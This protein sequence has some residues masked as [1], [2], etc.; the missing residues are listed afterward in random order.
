MNVWRT[1]QE[2]LRRR[3]GRGHVGKPHF[4]LLLC[5]Q[6]KSYQA[7]LL[8]LY[9]ELSSGSSPYKGGKFIPTPSLV[10]A[11]S[12]QASRRRGRPLLPPQLVLT[13]LCSYA[14]SIP[15]QT[16]QSREEYYMTEH[17]PVSTD[18]AE[19]PARHFNKIK[20]WKM[21]P[22]LEVAV[23]PLWALEAVGEP[24]WYLVA[25]SVR[26][27]STFTTRKA[28]A[29]VEFVGRFV[30]LTLLCAILNVAQWVRVWKFG[31]WEG[32]LLIAYAA[33]GVVLAVDYSVWWLKKTYS[34]VTVSQLYFARILT[35]A[36]YIPL[37]Y[38]VIYWIS[39]LC[40]GS[41]C[42]CTASRVSPGEFATSF[43]FSLVTWTNL[44]YGD[45]TPPPEI[46]LLVTIE[47]LLGYAFLGILIV[48]LLETFRKRS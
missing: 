46:R 9:R 40:S 15:E 28:P 19:E 16:S 13:R 7:P 47:A 21:R 42:G 36:L 6:F 10:V 17:S 3:P 37:F 1:R 14:C 4:M 31:T 33:S 41:A 45:L 11:Q 26:P 20:S 5:G 38:S 22:L 43:Y 27:G 29:E 30:A 12:L 32:Y 25:A 18:S 39:G 2:T 48:V 24:I 35:G 44:G 8:S 34:A 23:A